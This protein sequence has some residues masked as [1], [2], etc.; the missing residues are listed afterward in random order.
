MNIDKNT[1]S[2]QAQVRQD[3]LLEIVDKGGNYNVLFVGNSITRHEPK[4]EIGWE[5]DWGMAASAKE[6]DYVHVTIQQLEEK[7]GTINYATLNASCWERSYYQDE[8]LQVF[9]GAKAFQPDLVVIR[10]GENMWSAKDYFANHPIAKH[11]AKMVDYFT[12]TPNVKIIITDLFW[13]NATIDDAIHSVAKEKGYTLVSLSD[14]GE[15]QEN[16][17]IGKFWHEGVALHPGDLGMQRIGR[18]IAQAILQQMDDNSS[19]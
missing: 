19:L 5:N 15:N 17:A 13:K 9:E 12:F 4:K 8:G 16:M 1:V 11:Y 14:L 6:K 3:H 2:A 10:L 18:R 7:L